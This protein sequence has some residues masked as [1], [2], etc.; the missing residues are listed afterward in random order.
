MYANEPVEIETIHTGH[1]GVIVGLKHARTGDTLINASTLLRVE[2]NVSKKKQKKTLVQTQ[3][4]H[5]YLRDSSL[6]LRPIDVPPPVFFAALEPNTTSDEKPLDDALAILLREDPSLHI[7]TDDD[8]GQTLLSGMGE[9]H[10]EISKDRLVNDLKAK[11]SMGSIRIGYREVIAGRIEGFRKT[12]EREI[13]GNTTSAVITITMEAISSDEDKI[14]DSD[15][16]VSKSNVLGNEIIIELTHPEDSDNLNLPINMTI[17]SLSDAMTTGAVTAL[18][19]GPLLN[20]PMHSTRVIITVD[21]M[22]DIDD[23][24]SLSAFTSAC[25]TGITQALKQAGSVLMEPVM[26][27][28]INVDEGD[29]GTVVADISSGGGGGTVL[30]LDD[31]DAHSYMTSSSSTSTSSSYDTHISPTNVNEDS[32]L[33][34]LSAAAG[35]IDVDKVYA[36]PDSYLANAIQRDHGAKRGGRGLGTELGANKPRTIRARVPL[37]KMVGYN[38]H[39]RSLT[40][41]RGTFVMSVD[42]FE[43]MSDVRTRAVLMELRGEY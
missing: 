19:R 4:Q 8:S 15:S 28:V 40:K 22:S 12:Y 24:S 13:G 14:E 30:S 32:S 43:R 31:D 23:K 33:S 36:P 1:I 20:Y 11:A 9:L 25:R 17:E 41:G 21:T 6:Q 7:A 10:L 38:N 5:D 18:S 35:P 34:S 27:V 39:L 42:R 3:T 26:D 2:K 16:V 37:K 29:L